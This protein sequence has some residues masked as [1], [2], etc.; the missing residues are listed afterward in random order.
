M[1]KEKIMVP[2][3]KNSVW[4][5]FITSGKEYGFTSL[6]TKMMYSRVKLLIKMK[7]E[8]AHD[9]AIDI[10]YNFFVKNSKLVEEDLNLINS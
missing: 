8:S 6:A 4:K 3:K 9:E 5:K 10:A 1:P 7:G 2:D